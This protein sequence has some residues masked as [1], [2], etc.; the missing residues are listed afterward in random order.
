MGRTNGLRLPV[1]LAI[2]AGLIAVAALAVL[3]IHKAKQRLNV[4][5][6]VLDTVRADHLSP[7]GYDRDTTPNLARFA[8]EALL[9]E[10]ARA[11]APWTLPSHASLFTGE[12]P[13]VHG[14]DFEHRFLVPS[15]QT[16]AEDLQAEGY[17]TI[18]VS[19]NINVSALHNLDQGFDEF[20]EV[21]RLREQFHP[22]A[23][24]MIVNHLVG[25][26]LG[27]RPVRQPFFLFL[28][29]MDCH[30]PYTPDPPLDRLF[31]QPSDAARQAAARPDLL[32]AVLTGEVVIDAPLAQGLTDLYDGELRQLDQRIGE[33]LRALDERGLTESTLVIITSDHGELLGEDGHVDHQLSLREQLL[34]VPLLVRWPG[35]VQPGRVRRPVD[36]SRVAGWIRDAVQGQVPEWLPPPDREP[37]A[38]VAEYARPVDL[39]ERLKTRID[40]TAFDRRLAAGYRKDGEHEWKRVE[41]DVG[42]ALLLDVRDGD[43]GTDRSVEFPGIFR[44]LEE[45]LRQ[46]RWV[47]FVEYPEDL[48]AGP[49]P[50]AF[51]TEALAAL[52]YVARRP[53]EHPGMHAV[54]HWSA[55]MYAESIGQSELALL[56]IDKAA[57]IAPEHL[58][59]LWDHARLADLA[60]RA[61]AGARYEAFLDR[62]RELGRENSTEARQA[63][64]RRKE[65]P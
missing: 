24:S 43:E 65:L 51:E 3:K 42:S 49:H 21:W 40:V 19:S 16:V 52:G 22:R 41:D 34:R 48:L 4:V 61:D 10:H 26:W 53:G 28:N 59:I 31:G 63:A 12:A 33:L 14:C 8:E 46:H 58:G 47:N 1:I 44:G 6:V 56:E 2:M 60:E 45:A 32:E 38:L 36:L 5:L 35:R 20:H 15:R 64:Q 17:Q 29:Y 62:A 30:L 57:T 11:P 9:F 18:A 25:E 37:A 39:L 23:D 55:A 50:E 13:R 7:Y 27:R 54:E